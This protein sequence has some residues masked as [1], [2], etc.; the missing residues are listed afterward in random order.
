MTVY[1]RIN[2][3]KEWLDL[4]FQYLDKSFNVIFEDYNIMLHT[5][6]KY[7]LKARP[8]RQMLIWKFDGIEHK[9]FDDIYSRI[10]RV[11]PQCI[12]CVVSQQLYWD[13]SE[14][15]EVR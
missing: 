15:K 6:N 3:S 4:L 11:V 2:G 12:E 9:D 10:D 8:D 5:F 13:S 1:I 7:E 14:Y